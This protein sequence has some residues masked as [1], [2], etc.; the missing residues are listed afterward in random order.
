MLGAELELKWLGWHSDYV[1]IYTIK[2][3]LFDSRH[4]AQTASGANPVLYPLHTESA[5]SEGNFCPPSS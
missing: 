5:L 1:A 3:A 2:E 4:G